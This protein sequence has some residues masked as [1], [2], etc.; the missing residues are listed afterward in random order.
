MKTGLDGSG[1]D[2]QR[3]GDFVQPHPVHESQQQHFPVTRRKARHRWTKVLVHRIHGGRVGQL[4]RILAGGLFVAT[5]SPYSR[6]GA[7]AGHRVEQRTQLSRQEQSIAG[8][9]KLA[10]QV[11][12]G[13][14]KRVRSDL[15]VRAE[16][17]CHARHVV[18]VTPVEH[19]KSPDGVS[20]SPAVAD[21]D[22]LQVGQSIETRTGHVRSDFGFGRLHLFL[23]PTSPDISRTSRRRHVASRFSML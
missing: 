18:A 5:A 6:Q 10:Q 20:A 1:R 7:I 14:L 8:G 9:R 23:K 21:L 11:E 12:E 15:S 4:I 3:F 16:A 13:F 2:F 22:Q 19:T 17:Q